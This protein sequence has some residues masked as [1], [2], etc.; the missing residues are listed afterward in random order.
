MSGQLECSENPKTHYVQNDG[1]ISDVMDNSSSA[2]Y[3]SNLP[4][5]VG[6]LI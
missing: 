3:L 4:D 5:R 2:P 1:K 6:Y